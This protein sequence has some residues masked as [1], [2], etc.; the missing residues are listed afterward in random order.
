[1]TFKPCSRRRSLQIALS[2]AAGT[3]FKTANTHAVQKSHGTML[4]GFSTYGMRSLTTENAIRHIAAIGFDAVEITVWPDWDA[5]PANMSANRRK[6]IQAQLK[7][8][9]LTLTSLMEHLVPSEDPVEHR[10]QLSRLKNVFDLASDTAGKQRPIVQTVLGG[11][12]WASRKNFLK[13]R[14]GEWAELAKEYGQVLAIKPH[15]GGVMSRPEEAVWLIEQLGQPDELRLVY[16]YSHYAFRDMTLDETVAT[17]LPYVAHVAVKDPVQE[18][19]R[20]RFQLPG[21]AGSVPYPALL[22]KLQAGGYRG[23]ISCE[24]SGMVW[25]KPGYNPL[26]SARRC[27]ASLSQAFTDAGVSRPN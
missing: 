4:L 20:V 22:K 9:N 21:E 14:I 13:D 18:A 16:D 10:A 12:D 24:V 6:I 15:R 11:G 17:A 27:Y 1:M 23:D 25:S 26:Q 2:A 8:S 3:V 7:D 5:A 19:G